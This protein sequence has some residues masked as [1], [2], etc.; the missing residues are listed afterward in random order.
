[1]DVLSE[2]RRA[3][4]NANGMVDGAYLNNHVTVTMGRNTIFSGD[5]ILTTSYVIPLK[6]PIYISRSAKTFMTHVSVAK[7]MTVRFHF[8]DNTSIAVAHTDTEIENN[9]RIPFEM[10]TSLG[11]TLIGLSFGSSSHSWRDDSY[12]WT[13]I[14]DNRTVF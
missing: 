8:S 14:I 6:H 10:S 13:L 9:P 3:L 2:R 7:V 1:M 5:N 11:K 12:T 4:M